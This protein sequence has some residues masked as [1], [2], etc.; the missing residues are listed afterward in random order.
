M[1][2][3]GV[4]LI[5]YFLFPEVVKEQ[6]VAVEVRVD[7]DQVGDSLSAARSKATLPD[8]Q[9]LLSSA[10]ALAIDVSTGES[11]VPSDRTLNSLASLIASLISW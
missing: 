9:E 3:A 11:P 1:H 6:P 2:L 7:D 8:L 4:S 10:K 5:F